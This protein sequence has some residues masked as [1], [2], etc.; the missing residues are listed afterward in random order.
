MTTR[1]AKKKRRSVAAR[2]RNGS[3][4]ASSSRLE[5]VNSPDSEPREFGRSGNA[6][7]PSASVPAG[8]QLLPATFPMPMLIPP[9]CQGGPLVQ[10]QVPDYQPFPVDCF[11]LPVR[12]Y[13]TAQARVLNCDPAAV[14]LPVLSVLASAVGDRRI[15]IKHAWTEPANL[16]TALIADGQTCHTA[17]LQAAI[18]PLVVR[19]SRAFAQ[20]QQLM[21]E[22]ERLLT[23]YRAD[24]RL[25]RKE[26]GPEPDRPAVPPVARSVAADWTLPSLVRLLS[27]QR[28]GL[29]V[30]AHEMD[31]WLG[32][33]LGSG[34]RASLERQAWFDLHEGRSVTIESRSD[35]P[36][37][38]LD[39]VPVSV[40]GSLSEELL[41]EKLTKASGPSGLASRLL[42]AS[43]PTHALQWTDDDVEQTVT[44]GYA[45]VIDLLFADDSTRR[46]GLAGE[47]RLAP[48][49]KDC[50]ATFIQDL[51][52]AQRG[53]DDLLFTWSTNLAGQAARLA[54]VLHLTRWAAGDADD[55]TV[56]DLASVQRG[57]ALAR[58]FA[59]EA[60]RVVTRLSL[61]LELLDDL[62]LIDWLRRRGGRATPRDLCRSNRRKYPTLEAATNAFSR[63]A[64][65]GLTDWTA[66]NSGPNGGRP[67]RELMLPPTPGGLGGK[68]LDDP[69]SQPGGTGIEDEDLEGSLSG[70]DPA[71]PDWKPG[72]VSSGAI[73]SGDDTALDS[74]RRGNDAGI[75]TRPKGATR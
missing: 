33:A 20:Q 53:L 30:C 37:L 62:R 50:L 64:G 21:P 54:L 31:G 63:L 4:G 58:W 65:T 7:Q 27:K 57:I 24:V 13:I 32:R 52:V 36:S 10:N 48:A 18:A 44:D 22:Y 35:R 39:P 43:P 66:R 16:W 17:A 75:V 41:T 56:C 49:A 23:R 40:T 61:E 34:S 47:V 46:E 42:F 25:A 70:V 26:Q 69:L 3:A 28:R 9:D 73:V 5:S 67:T 38:H 51:S 19:Q 15:R 12:D 72:E 45:A 8:P 55:A 2:S 59:Y 29:L 71:D 11:P 68:I 1:L 60:Q 6:P 14:A 74:C